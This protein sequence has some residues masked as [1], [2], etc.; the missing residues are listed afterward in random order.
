MENA[1]GEVTLLLLEVRNGHQEAEERLIPLVY[2]EL[3]RLAASYLRKESPDHTLQPTAL[4][5]EAYLRL[6]RME[7][8]D[9]Q[10]RA[11]FFAVAAKLMRHI[12]VDHARAHQANKR[13]QGWKIVGLDEAFLAAPGRA[14]EI[15]ALNDA[16][17]RLAEL[18][19]R[20]CRI[21]ELRF[22]SGLNEEETGH[23][24]GITSRTVRRDWRLARAWLYRELSAGTLPENQSDIRGVRPKS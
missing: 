2:K 20:Q 16:L 12:L 17:D 19:S 11:H 18:D 7:Q 15:I 3:R 14:P 1:P 9:W 10:S 13:G 5:H 4:V 24:L 22:F 6:T 23:I 8:M 21:V